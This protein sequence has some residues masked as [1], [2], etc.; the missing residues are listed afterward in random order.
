MPPSPQPD[1][2]P[3]KL[4]FRR[5]TSLPPETSRIQGC[6]TPIPVIKKM[7]HLKIPDDN[8]VQGETV[9]IEELSPEAIIPDSL[10]ILR[11]PEVEVPDDDD[12]SE[13]ELDDKFTAIKL[14][15]MHDEG[16]QERRRKRT[17]SPRTF[18][19]IRGDN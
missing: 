5:A 3:C 1:F 6:S 2:E 10:T 7:R 9:K 16:E 14:D 17:A 15:G 8:Q 19:P 12:L 18:S 13:V 11:D 4:S